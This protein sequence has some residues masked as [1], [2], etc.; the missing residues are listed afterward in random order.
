M[1][2]AEAAETSSR[3]AFGP[4]AIASIIDHT[5]LKPDSTRTQIEQ[6]CREAIEHHFACAFVNP[7]WTPLAVSIARGTSIKIGAPVG[8]PLGA[9]LTAT[10]RAEAEDLVRVG[11]HELDMVLNIGALKSGDRKLVQTDIAA[12]AEIAHTAGASLK[13]ILETCLLS[14]EEK[15]VACEL[16]VLAGA[17]YVKTSTGFSTSGATIED[18]A[19]M[20]G[21]VGDRAGVKASGGIR[22]ANDA[23]AMVEAGASRLGTSSGVQILRE[24]RE[25][26]AAR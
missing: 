2:I 14:L 22:S 1:K 10:K 13:V 26:N 15:I 17:D 11:V 23:I 9:N 12:V 8:F 6:L 19:L 20:R 3:L 25:L 18:V 16:S 21:V 7:A 24:L 5:L 4:E